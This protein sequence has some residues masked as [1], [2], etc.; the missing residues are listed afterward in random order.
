MEIDSWYKWELF[1]SY[2]IA[3]VILILSSIL[4]AIRTKEVSIYF[5]LLGFLSFLIGNLVMMN[6]NTA[7]VE[8]AQVHGD[9]GAI[10]IQYLVGRA[11]SSLG[12]LMAGISLLLFSA[13]RKFR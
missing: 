9:K 2:Y 6:A 8:I 10:E 1:F 3:Q 5:C 4:M 11:M 13:R 7:L 12:F